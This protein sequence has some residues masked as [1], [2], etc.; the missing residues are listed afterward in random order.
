MCC[1]GNHWL[2]LMALSPPHCGT[3]VWR[4]RNG[5]SRSP[6][7]S[8]DGGGWTL[9]LWQ[10]PYCRPPRSPSS[11]SR[12]L[13]PSVQ[14][15]LSSLSWCR[16]QGLSQKVESGLGVGGEAMPPQ[17][18]LRRNGGIPAC[19][20]VEILSAPCGAGAGMTPAQIPLGP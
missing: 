7:S 4:R 18:Q 10:P 14:G 2:L 8:E 17:F 20:P 15:P 3:G 13:G 19:I 9:S 16:F 6:P 12:L 11:N 1:H 5:L